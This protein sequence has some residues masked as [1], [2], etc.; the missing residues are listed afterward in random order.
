MKINKKESY[1]LTG[2]QLN[3][4]VPELQALKGVINAIRVACEVKQQRR[5]QITAEE[6]DALVGPAYKL[7]IFVGKLTV[8]VPSAEDVEDELFGIPVTE[9]QKQ[10]VEEPLP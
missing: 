1:G 10:Q 2:V 9:E 7:A 4:S 5:L 3:L 8:D 6:F